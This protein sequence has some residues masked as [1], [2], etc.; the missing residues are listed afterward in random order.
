MD[1]A[2][3]Q[4]QDQ[5]VVLHLH[6]IGG[7]GKTALLEHWKHT[8]EISL[9]LD[10]NRITHLFDRLESIARNAAQLGIQLRR[11]DLLWSIRL[12]FIKGIEPAKEP[13][14]TW[15]YD[16]IKPLPFIGSLVNISKAIHTIGGKLKNR[17]KNKF[18]DVAD[19]LN[20]RLGS[21]YSEKLL[22]I[23]WKDPHHA[24]FLFLDALLEDLNARKDKDQSLLLLFDHMEN[25]DTEHLQW[26]YR[27]RKISETE[28]WFIF[29][30]S[31]HNTVGVT[32][33]R[34]RLPKSI[35]VEEL[36]ITELDTQSCHQLLAERGITENEIQTQITSVSGG[37]PFVL[38]TICD[39]NEFGKLSLDDIE[40]LRADTL[41]QV[42]IKTWRRLFNQ[43][44]DLSDIIDRAGLL[45]FFN[46]QIMDII[47][48]SLKSA[49]WDQIL[50]LSF[51]QDRGDGTWTLHALARE[52]VLAELGNTLPSY[53][54]EVANLLEQSAADNANPTYQGLAISAKTLIDET[55]A[56][57][58][59]SNFV[60]KLWDEFRFQDALSMIDIIPYKT[61]ESHAIM[62]WLR[63][64]VTGNLHHVAEA[65]QDFLE[66]LLLFKKF[67]A[68]EP[69]KYLPYLIWTNFWLLGIFRV[70]GQFAQVEDIIQQNYQLIKRLSKM[71]PDPI[72]GFQ[73][74]NNTFL[75][76]HYYA[77]ARFLMVME[78]YNE[79]EAAL[80]R[81]YEIT[82]E[83]TK[84]DTS[85]IAD[86]HTVLY[87]L[88]ILYLESGRNREAENTLQEMERVVSIH[89]TGRPLV[90]EGVVLEETEYMPFLTG[91]ARNITL[92]STGE[93]EK[94]IK[95]LEKAIESGKKYTGDYKANPNSL[96][97]GVQGFGL[98][99][100]M[101]KRTNR[102]TQA[103]EAFEEALECARLGYEKEPRSFIQSYGMVLNNL[104]ILQCQL[105]HISEATSGFQE[106]LRVFRQLADQTPELY[107][108]YLAQAINNYAIHLRKTGNLKQAE[109][110]IRE[111]LII[112]RKRAEK[113][114]D[115]YVYQ[116]ASSLNNLGV[117][118][119][120]VKKFN[121][122]RDALLEAYQL[123]KNLFEKA[124]KLYSQDYATTLTNL[125]L[126]MKHLEKLQEAEQYYQEAIRIWESLAAK[127]PDTYQRYL[128]QSLVNLAFLHSTNQASSDDF[129]SIMKKLQKLGVSSLPEN[130]IWFENEEEFFRIP[131]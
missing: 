57:L 19:W 91:P 49:D 115:Y 100:I 78:R 101:L 97:L 34:R 99:G 92:L 131:D 70:T 10:C 128:T 11:F 54:S 86:V 103:N 112:R 98:L 113:N 76:W 93:F 37:N 1:N 39:M 104:A 2:L 96:S 94:E 15:A 53:V 44:K 16:V 67:T 120:E 79:A 45:P 119:A 80:K 23:L 52:L 64:R 90:V 27:G 28:L 35:T 81:S 85:Y 46:R 77:Y 30:S 25:V 87:N 32:A 47:T 9:L 4:C 127:A 22:E 71:Q 83:G 105:N 13:G 62:K 88:I 124:P 60:L 41:E 125:G 42:R 84:T 17:L 126:I 26:R 75:A 36:E 59:C 40:N 65:E 102:L 31:L 72:F 121:K 24:E 51:I 68:K 114:P 55:G 69:E 7:I 21:D 38:H 130:E 48:P 63:G 20:T 18:G 110:A 33:S 56:I 118:L 106:S 82:Q 58:E 5:S 107:L 3:T 50:Q 89:F 129:D 74:L 73:N 8:I 109:S 123:R 29:L 43:A 117:I 61:E 6:G 116:V 66:A 12:R 122:A 111:A 14:R 95:E 108:P